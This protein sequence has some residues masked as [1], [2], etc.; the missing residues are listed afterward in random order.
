MTNGVC[1]PI[2]KRSRFRPMPVVGKFLCSVST[3]VTSLVENLLDATR[4]VNMKFV[5]RRSKSWFPDWPN[6][7]PL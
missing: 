5:F 6:M 2:Q 1:V 4:K 3:K 7:Y